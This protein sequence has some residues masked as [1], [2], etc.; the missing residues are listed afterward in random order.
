MLYWQARAAQQGGQHDMALRL[1]QQI[2]ADYPVH[3]YTTQGYANLQ[4]VGVRSAHAA[5]KILPI[6]PVL[7][8]DP[9]LLPEPSQRP[10]SKAHFHLVRVQELQQLQMYQP[11]GQEIRS[12]AALLPSTPAAQYSLASF[13]VNNQQHVAAFRALNSVLEALSP[14]EVRGLPRDFWTTLYPQVF[15]PE[16]SQL[17]QAISLNPYLV[18]SIIRQE[19]AF[20]PAAISSAGA[21][22]LMQLMPATAQ[23]VLTKLKLPQEP[24]RAAA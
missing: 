6:T 19:S 8:Q 23:E 17:A 5:G 4:A 21:R 24:C 16:V 1:Y 7:L 14:A 15:W 11:A 12:L 22:G 10:P 20:N 2:V 13:Y 9:A 3:Y 18:L